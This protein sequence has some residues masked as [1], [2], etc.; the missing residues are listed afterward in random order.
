MYEIP[1]MAGFFDGEGCIYAHP[2]ACYIQIEV[3]QVDR[4]PL[5][6]FQENYGGRIRLNKTK[7]RSIYKWLCPSGSIDRF[8]DEMLPFLIVKKEQA[9]LAKEY[10]LLRM[11]HNSRHNHNKAHNEIVRAQRIDICRLI[12]EAKHVSF[13]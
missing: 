5:L 10:R 1:Y 2:S 8:L 12:T 4:R 3:A 7:G 11:M 6:K 9:I 13:A